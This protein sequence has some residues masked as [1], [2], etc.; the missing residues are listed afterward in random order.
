M[1][2]PDAGA[3]RVIFRRTRP[4]RRAIPLR[5]LPAAASA[6]LSVDRPMGREW[7]AELP[8][9]DE[10]RRSVADGAFKTYSVLPCDHERL[11]LARLS[12]GVCPGLSTARARGRSD[13]GR[14]AGAGSGNVV[15]RAGTGRARRF[16]GVGW[17][18]TAEDSFRPSGTGRA[19]RAKLLRPPLAGRVG[20]RRHP[21]RRSPHRRMRGRAARLR[22]GRHLERVARGYRRRQRSIH[23][24]A[25]ARRWRVSRPRR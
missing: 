16:V 25:A 15:G 18:R 2:D 19:D 13:L 24:P 14:A 12:R 4:A 17:F 7:R 5:P 1:V 8:I 23:S 11:R 21:G 3:R 6:G 22:V 20:R 9:S 10:F